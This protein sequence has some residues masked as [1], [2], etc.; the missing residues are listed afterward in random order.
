M[1]LSVNGQKQFRFVFELYNDITPITCEN[2]R[3]LCTGE[4][5]KGEVTGLPLHFKGAPF[6]RVITNFMAQGGDF[7]RDHGMKSE[8]IY[9]GRFKDENFNVKHTKPGLLSMANAG[10]NTNGAQFF[11]CF[12]PCDWLDGKHTVFGE[13]VEG[14]EQLK[15]FESLGSDNGQTKADIRIMDCGEVKL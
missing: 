4:K 15:A 14:I 11:I 6:A 13:V 9:G 7:A 8:S 10:P 1:E 3:A 5:G 12:V 2:F